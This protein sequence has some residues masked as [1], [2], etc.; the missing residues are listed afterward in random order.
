[1]LGSEE[2]LE[3]ETEAI[4]ISSEKTGLE[5]ERPEVQVSSVIRKGG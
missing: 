3:F 2:G 1:L 5:E 4:G